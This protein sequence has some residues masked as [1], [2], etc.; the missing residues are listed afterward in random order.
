MT[1]AQAFHWFDRELASAEI[2]RVLR[3][4][5]VL[6][7]LWNNSDPGCTWDRACHRIA[8]PGLV[9][10]GGEP[11][12]DVAL[13]D[14]ATPPD[15]STIIGVLPGFVFERMTTH[16]WFERT[17]RDDYVRRWLTVS[18]FLAADP[19]TRARM[20]ADV[21]RVLDTD[22]ATAGGAEFDLPQVTDVFVYRRIG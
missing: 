21:E 12:E 4:G 3:P 6:G 1:V 10:E 15:P 13:A 7:M 19:V 22:P 20:V 14:A 17:T 18:T 9:G 2:H 5:G 11:A 8:H 16:P